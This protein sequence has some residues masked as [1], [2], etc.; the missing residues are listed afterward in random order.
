M[1]R[2]AFELYDNNEH[3]IGN[4]GPLLTSRRFSMQRNEAEMLN[5]SLDLSRF[6]RW[7]RQELNMHPRTVLSPYQTSIRVSRDGTYL[8]GSQ[9]VSAPVTAGKGSQSIEIAATGYLNL[10][11]DRYT[12]ATFAAID[13]SLIPFGLIASEQAKPYG[14]V[15]VT[16]ASSPYLTGVP[17]DR[18]YERD[19][20]KQ[21][22]QALTAL[23][24]G[25]FDFAFSADKQFQ[26][27]EKVGVR[28]NEFEFIYGG[29]ASN[30]KEL[31]DPNTATGL[32]NHIYGLGSGFGPDQLVDERDDPWSMQLYF[33]RE[34]LEHFSSVQTPDVLTQ[35]TLAALEVKKR[36]LN[37]P[38]FTITGRELKGGFIGVGDRIPIATSGHEFLDHINGLFRVEMLSVK[39]DDNDFEEEVDLH[40]DYVGVDP[41]EQPT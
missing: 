34:R 20:V 9:V 18:N 3:F 24:D 11:A 21:A 7:C 25:A 14:S 5:A 15:G 32:F 26:V 6:E 31:Y 17:R 38:R 12:L 40:F 28:R 37:I 39:L 36:P 35:N 19:N 23:T 29:P 8:F 13:A 16:L 30:V 10:F 33:R 22:I 27:Y 4:I 1:A 41:N 2:Y